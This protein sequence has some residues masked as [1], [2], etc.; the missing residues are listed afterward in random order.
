M[1]KFKNINYKKVKIKLGKIIKSNLINKG[2]RILIAFSGGPDSVFLYH[3]IE[4][5][6]ED[7]KLEI[8][9]LYVNHNIRTDIKKDLEFVEEFSQKKGITL[10]VENVNVND[11][12][13]EKR[14]SIELAARELRYEKLYE[15]MKRINYNK[16]ATGHNL[17]DNVETVVFRLLR[18]TSMRGL[19]GIPRKRDNIVRP[20]LEFEKSEILDFLE[21]NNEKYITLII[22]MT[23]RGIT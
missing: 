18:G 22:R 9:L 4:Y 8:S 23:I 2:D 10:Y 5:L 3:I 13:L 1:S 19:K 16:I 6:K 11:Y 14:K 7:F 12:A 21:D 20:I 15:V 17:D